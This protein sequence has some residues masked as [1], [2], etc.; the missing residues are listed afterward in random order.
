MTA[1]TVAFAVVVKLSSLSLSSLSSPLLL[2]VLLSSSL[3]SSLQRRHHHKDDCHV[4]CHHN[5]RQMML[6]RDH[7]G[8]ICCRRSA[9]V[10]IIQIMFLCSLAANGGIEEH[11]LWIHTNRTRNR[12]ELYQACE[13]KPWTRALGIDIRYQILSLYSSMDTNRTRNRTELYQCMRSVALD[14]SS[15]Y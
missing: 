7:D 10:V 4:G 5:Y 11:F 15:G 8:D 3:L 12:T 2:K 13:A 14:P 6:Q 1:T 9:R